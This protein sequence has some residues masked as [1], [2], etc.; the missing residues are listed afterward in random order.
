MA[1]EVTREK[2]NFAMARKVVWRI[3]SEKQDRFG[4]TYIIWLDRN[5]L[6]PVG[7]IERAFSAPIDIPDEYFEFPAKKPWRLEL[8]LEDYA[9]Y[10]KGKLQEWEQIY[11]AIRDKRPKQEDD[12]VALELAGP[13]PQDWRLIVLMMRG[14]PWCLGFTDQRTP[15]VVA[16]IGPA[17]TE[18]ELRRER[19]EPK[20]LRL[21]PQLDALS[22]QTQ[23]KA[24]W[25]DEADDEAMALTAMKRDQALGISGSDSVLDG[26]NLD[27]V[28]RG[29]STV[30]EEPEFDIPGD[31]D[32]D[33]SDGELTGDPLIDLKEPLDL[34]DELEEKFDPQA[35]GGKKH[36]PRR[37]RTKAGKE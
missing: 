25:R 11:K 13:K 37:N 33:G 20:D 7:Q 29:E 8:K 2:L 36:N 1:A 5:N 19:E 15:A 16:I 14:D 12:K 24:K 23:Y 18:A 28:E 32:D 21:D 17:P 6:Q 30:Y 34:A 10:L 22:R 35:L 27:S 4:R 31:L 9:R 3:P 26:G